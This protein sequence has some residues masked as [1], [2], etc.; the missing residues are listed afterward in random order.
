[1]ASASVHDAELSRDE[2]V[3]SEDAGDKVTAEEQED[4]QPST[5]PPVTERTDFKFFASEDD[6]D[7]G[8]MVVWHAKV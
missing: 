8:N 3:A 6:S 7:R 4:T 1:M 2:E 5:L